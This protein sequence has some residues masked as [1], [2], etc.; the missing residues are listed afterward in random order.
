LT[1]IYSASSP[2]DVLRDAKLRSSYQRTPAAAAPSVR[3]RERPAVPSRPAG[4]VAAHRLR[5]R[6]ASCRFAA[7]GGQQSKRARPNIRGA[8][9]AGAILCVAQLVGTLAFDPREAVPRGAGRDPAARQHRPRGRRA[10]QGRAPAARRPRR[11]ARLL[12]AARLPTDAESRTSSN[13]ARN[14]RDGKAALADEAVCAICKAL[15]AIRQA[16]E[17]RRR[18]SPARLELDPLDKEIRLALQTDVSA[19]EGRTMSRVTESI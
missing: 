8:L 17:P 11:R 6:R 12:E 16:G 15:A 19:R 2:H 1:E 7:E 10:P 18:A 3:L 13:L 9:L 14:R 5:S 4:F